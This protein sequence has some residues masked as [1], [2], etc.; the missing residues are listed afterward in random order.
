MAKTFVV[1]MTT[2]TGK[3]VMGVFSTREKASEERKAIRRVRYPGTSTPVFA[4]ER[5]EIETWEMDESGAFLMFQA[6]S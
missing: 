5:V 6:A 1:T 4:A 2:A 3:T